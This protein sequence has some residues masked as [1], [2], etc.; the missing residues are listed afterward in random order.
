MTEAIPIYSMSTFMV[1]KDV[2]KQMD[3]ISRGSGRS[4]K[5]GA[6]RHLALKLWSSICKPKI[7]GGL[8]FKRIE[9][10]F[11][12]DSCVANM[13]RRYENMVDEFMEVRRTIKLNGFK[14]DCLKCCIYP[15]SSRLAVNVDA[16]VKGSKSGV[17]MVVRNAFGN[18][19]LADAKSLNAKSVELAEIKALS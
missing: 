13:V 19:M 2:C 17:G 6:K 12:G 5:P 8:G 1:L 10:L 14:V 4:T 15:L 9:M 3:S 18:V 16:T 11:L 7:V